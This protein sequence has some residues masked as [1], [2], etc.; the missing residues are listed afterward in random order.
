[1]KETECKKWVDD[2]GSSARWSELNGG[3]AI[4]YKYP[5]PDEG[6]KYLSVLGGGTKGKGD[7]TKGPHPA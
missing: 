4:I 6:W 5:D 3:S 7:T 1:M 2:K